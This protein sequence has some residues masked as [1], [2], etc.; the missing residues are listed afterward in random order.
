MTEAG[1]PEPER[2]S[3]GMIRPD[4]AGLPETIT[5]PAGYRMRT[6]RPGDEAAWAELMNTGEMG[7][8]TAERAAAELTGRPWPQFDPL[9]LFCITT[10]AD[11]HVV[12]SACAWLLDPSETVTGT[13]HMVC[14]APGHRG[15]RLGYS[16]CLAVLH[17]FRERGFAAVQLTTNDFR[18]GAVK[19][20]LQLGFLPVHSHPLHADQWKQVF[21]QLRWPHPAEGIHR[22]E[23]SP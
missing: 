6:Y 5:L 8:W 19:E 13:L 9:G 3:L 16:V 4:L 11:E 22:G 1:H 20:Y 15:R 17:R 21:H 14:V 18:L 23:G 10:D 7:T 2:P 12:G